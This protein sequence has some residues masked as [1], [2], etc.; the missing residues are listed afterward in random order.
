[1]KRR[2]STAALL[3]L[4]VAVFACAPA[5]EP[6]PVEEPEV[7][8]AAVIEGNVSAFEAAYNAKDADAVAA[9]YTADG[10]RMPPNAPA[11]V[12]GEAIRAAYDETFAQ[13]EVELSLGLDEIEVAGDIAYIR[14]TYEVAITPEGGEA[15]GDNGKWINIL[16]RQADGCWLISHAIFNSNNPI[17]GT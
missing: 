3:A 11:N 4:A 7:D 5:E 9:R 6:E 14:G 2:L 16:E 10:I 12:G 15:Q 13:A 17:E 1:M 8:D